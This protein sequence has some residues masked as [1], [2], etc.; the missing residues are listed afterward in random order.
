VRRRCFHLTQQQRLQYKDTFAAS[1]DIE[2]SRLVQV[3][4][5]ISGW[6]QLAFDISV[7]Y[8]Q[9]AADSTFEVPV[10]YPKGYEMTGDDGVDYYYLY[11][12]LSETEKKLGWC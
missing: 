6:S 1:P 5:L 2:T 11:Y 7:A 3:L 12:T 4:A 8:L 10:M 9:S